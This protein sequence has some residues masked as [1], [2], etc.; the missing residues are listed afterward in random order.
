M[1]LFASVSLFQ[2]RC[3][4]YC[5]R[6][7]L[8]PCAPSSHPP[9]CLFYSQSPP[10]SVCLSVC[11]SLSLTHPFTFT[12]SLSHTCTQR[13]ANESVT[14]PTVKTESPAGRGA[15]C[16]IRRRNHSLPLPL[17]LPL[18]LPASLPLPP[19]LPLP[20]PL[21]CSLGSRVI[22][23]FFH[24]ALPLV[25]PSQSRAANMSPDQWVKT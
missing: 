6:P 2:R 22:H 17:P 25:H 8:S 23:V 4:R 14:S 21:P 5:C 18:S 12:Q 16:E 1:S 11:L 10:L 24:L 7:H 9:H 19:L 13:L 20:L 15:L 3:D